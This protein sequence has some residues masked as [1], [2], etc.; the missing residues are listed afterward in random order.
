AMRLVLIGAGGAAVA[1]AAFALIS[2]TH[3]RK[4]GTGD[5]S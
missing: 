3:R 2:L 5:E 1:V 4:A